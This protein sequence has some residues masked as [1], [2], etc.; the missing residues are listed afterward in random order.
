MKKLPFCLLLIASL[1]F[2]FKSHADQL[3]MMIDMSIKQMKLDSNFSEMTQC[4]NVSESLFISAMTK[5]MRYCFEKHGKGDSSE[6]AMDQCFQSKSLKNLNISSVVYK[7]CQQQFSDDE[8]SQNTE[9][10][11]QNS[12]PFEGMTEQQVRQKIAEQQA[13]GMQ[14]LEQM[15]DMIK[16]M[17]QGTE[18]LISLPIYQP[19]EIASHYTSGMDKQN[20]NKTLPVATFTTGSSVTQVVDFYK[21]ALSDFE[22]DHAVGDVYTLMKKIPNNLM[23]LSFDLENL[24]LYSIPH[25]EI[26]SLKMNGKQQTTIVIVY[27]K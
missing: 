2:S 20:G 25:I 27:K 24:P 3:D 12:D 10:N 6:Q 9:T 1:N 13:Q 22:M 7:K 14:Q 11:E 19:S 23:E 16:G 26:Y 18:G 5:T 17:S 8:S 4:L 21:K 15:A